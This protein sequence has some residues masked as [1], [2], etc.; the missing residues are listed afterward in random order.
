MWTFG[1]YTSADNRI[2]GNKREEHMILAKWKDFESYTCNYRDGTARILARRAD[3]CSAKAISS[4]IRMKNCTAE[5]Q[6]QNGSSFRKPKQRDKKKQRN[7]IV[8]MM[9]R[10]SI[11]QTQI[12]TTF[13]TSIP[14]LNFSAGAQ[15]CNIFFFCIF[16]A[17]SIRTWTVLVC[18]SLYLV[19][20]RS[21][22]HKFDNFSPKCIRTDEKQ[23]QQLKR[24]TARTHKYI[25]HTKKLFIAR[26]VVHVISL[27]WRIYFDFSHA[28]FRCV[29]SVR[30]F[31][32]HTHKICN[33]AP[34][35]MQPPCLK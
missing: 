30:L 20:F 8:C 21:T 23:K 17:H 4:A 19:V 32:T 24:I 11:P 27:R 12:K 31:H 18:F 29:P 28:F 13:F 3:N 35:Q 5:Q 25:T 7:W 14:N 9:F 2:G 22:A 15:D 33:N 1:L 26:R 16:F 34:G 6:L 10:S